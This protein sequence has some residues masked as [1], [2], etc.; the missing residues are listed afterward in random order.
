MLEPDYRGEP[1]VLAHSQLT[2][3]KPGQAIKALE[4]LG[5][6]VRKTGKGKNPH[7]VLTKQGNPAIISIPVHKGKDVK[8][9]LIA[10]QLKRAGIETDDFLDALKKRVK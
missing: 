10:D 6:V 5:W 2:N 9:G 8:P 4:R 3:L 1:P 7:K